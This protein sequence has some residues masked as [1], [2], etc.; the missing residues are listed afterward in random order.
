V[1][2]VEVENQYRIYVGIDWATEAHQACVLDQRGGLVAERSFAHSGA[3]IADFAQWLLELAGGEPGQVAIAIEVPRGPVVEALVERGFEVY[4]INPKQLDRFRDRYSVAGAKD[5]RR[6]AFVLG[7][8]LRT[9][10][11][12]FRRVRLDDPLIIQLR[13]LSRVNEEL[14]R[15]ANQLANRLRDQLHRFY[16]QALALCPAANEPWLWDLLALAPSPAAA[17]RLRPQRV[18][19]VLRRHRIRRMRAREVVQ[20]LKAPALQ[21]A[22]GV[23]EAATEHIALLLPRLRLVHSQHK[24]C[25]ARLEAL[26]DQIQAVEPDDGEQREHH[27]VEIFR[28]L[29]G[30]GSVVAAAVLGEAAQALAERDYHALR[31]NAG[32]APVTKQSGKRRTVVMRYACNGRLRNALFHWAQVAIM[33]DPA[34]K[35]YYTALRQRGHSWPRTLRSVA[36]RLLRV[37]FAMLKS[38]SLFDSS[39]KSQSPSAAATQNAA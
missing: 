35:A 6:D 23:V 19:P 14:G 8:S 29:P 24:Q 39:R 30:V 22:P 18:E 2:Q 31:A 15:E 38:G 11:A 21:V 26:L 7:D 5:D 17:R 20:A 16:A 4:A 36:D 27:D 32:I 10:R 3:A 33:H 25:G 34:S 1:E 9:D 28:S 13:E 37:L 12:R